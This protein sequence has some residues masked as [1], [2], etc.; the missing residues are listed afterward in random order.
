MRVSKTGVVF[1]FAYTTETLQIRGWRNLNDLGVCA[2]L[3]MFDDLDQWL[4]LDMGVLCWGVFKGLFAIVEFE[5][6]NEEFAKLQVRMD[7]LFI[8]SRAP[9]QLHALNRLFPFPRWSLLQLLGVLAILLA[10]GVLKTKCF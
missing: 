1:R 2:F 9:L 10:L 7:V 4:S 5:L 3:F 8:I 6:L